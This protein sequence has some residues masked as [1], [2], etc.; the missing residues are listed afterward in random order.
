MK[1]GA[2]VFLSMLR[3]CPLAE[4]IISPFVF[5]AITGVGGCLASRLRRQATIFLSLMVS[6]TVA[7]LV[8]IDGCRITVP[9]WYQFGFFVAGP[10]S[11]LVVPAIICRPERSRQGVAG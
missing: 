3:A 5:Q 4:V 1:V 9:W 8:A 10:I 11:V 6:L 2:G 7:I